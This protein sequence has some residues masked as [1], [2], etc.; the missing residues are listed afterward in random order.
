MAHRLKDRASKLLDEL[1]ISTQPSLASCS[2]VPHSRIFIFAR[3]ELMIINEFRY[4]VVPDSSMPTLI[5]QTG[6][7]QT[8]TSRVG[9]KMHISHVGESMN[10]SPPIFG[11]LVDARISGQMG[12]VFII[13]LRCNFYDFDQAQIF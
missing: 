1:I 6:E 5:V 12:D 13:S 7:I 2:P 11:D 9:L 10:G 4:L 3:L 8:W